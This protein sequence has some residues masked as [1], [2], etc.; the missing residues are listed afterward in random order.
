[1]RRRERQAFMRELCESSVGTMQ[2]KDAQGPKKSSRRQTKE[3][4]WE[5]QQAV[6]LLVPTTLI[7]PLFLPPLSFLSSIFLPMFVEHLLCSKPH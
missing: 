4:Q 7:F 2:T 5:S 3:P 6:A 1:M